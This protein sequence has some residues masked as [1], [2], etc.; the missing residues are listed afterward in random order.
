MRHTMSKRS[1]RLINKLEVESVRIVQRV[2]DVRLSVP[3]SLV[4]EPELVRAKSAS[5]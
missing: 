1:V 5:T 2:A 3:L 4:G